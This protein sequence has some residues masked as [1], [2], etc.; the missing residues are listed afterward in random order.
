MENGC[1][2]WGSR[3]VIP[4]ALQ[5]Q[6]LHLLHAEHP[7][8]TRMKQ[9][10]RSHVYWPNID[11]D[12][13]QLVKQCGVCQVTQNARKDVQVRPWNWSTQPWRRLF[14]DFAKKYGLT[15]I[16]VVDHHSKFPF[17]EAMTKTTATDVI[18]YLRTLFA[19]FGL[20]NELVCDNGPPFNSQEFSQF[21]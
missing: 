4:Y 2:L 1:I 18:D 20:P 13:E 7:G 12:I 21:L 15:F 16:V 17:V 19:L 11:K 6:I 14:V 10:A 8:E 3:V 5:P 9:L